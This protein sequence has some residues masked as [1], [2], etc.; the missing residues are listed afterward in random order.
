LI[1]S[2]L[3]IGAKFNNQTDQTS[4]KQIGN[5]MEEKRWTTSRW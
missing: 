1:L 3:H 2:F 4:F 5:K